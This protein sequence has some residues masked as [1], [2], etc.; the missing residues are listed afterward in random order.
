MF[1]VGV[2]ASGSSFILDSFSAATTAYSV[3]R[4]RSGYTG[5]AMTVRRSSDNAETDVLFDSTYQVSNSS[6]V[7]AGGTFSAWYGAS[8]VFVKTW[9]DQSTNANHATQSTTANQPRIVNAG[10]LDTYNGRT[11]IN[12]NGSNSLDAADS[13]S[14]DLNTFLSWSAVQDLPDPTPNNSSLFDKRTPGGNSTGYHAYFTP[15][16]QYGFQW[17]GTTGFT[18]PLVA[19]GTSA[20]ILYSMAMAAE[21]GVILER[22]RNNTSLGTAIIGTVGSTV[23]ASPFR[24]GGHMDTPTSRLLGN[25]SEFLL[26]PIQYTSS[27]QNYIFQNQ[28]LFFTI[29]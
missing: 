2:P 7:S 5:A 12:F 16:R 6:L 15:T 9:Y 22:F 4:L 23:N 10:T 3:R 24:L 28:K 11:T 27:S 8:S 25:L 26:F 19:S 29:A 13:A 1:N 21:K 17:N 14:L 18:N 20:G